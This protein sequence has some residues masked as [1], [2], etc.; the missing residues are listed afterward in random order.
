M[1]DQTGCNTQEDR[2]GK[3]K[4]TRAG[5]RARRQQDRQRRQGKPNLFDE[6]PRQQNRMS[7]VQEKFQ[8]FVHGRPGTSDVLTSL[9]REQYA[10]N[11]RSSQIRPVAC[12][13]AGPTR[14]HEAFLKANRDCLDTRTPFLLPAPNTSGLR[15][16]V[17]ASLRPS[18]PSGALANRVTWPPP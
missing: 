3:A 5:E 10:P 6:Y 7:M 1:G 17:A 12:V 14:V 8:R 11:C 9:R 4:F 16:P 13:F 18:Q 2:A 15:T